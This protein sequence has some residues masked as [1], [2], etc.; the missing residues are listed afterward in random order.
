[1]PTRANRSGGFGRR[2]RLKGTSLPA[3]PRS[4]HPAFQKPGVEATLAHPEDGHHASAAEEDHEVLHL[5]LLT[6]QTLTR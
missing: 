6:R 4:L 3:E 1:M 2:K 5:D